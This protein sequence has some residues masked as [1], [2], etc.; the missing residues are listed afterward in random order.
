MV[1]IS[2]TTLGNDPKLTNMLFNGVNPPTSHGF[3]MFLK[4]MGSPVSCF[5]FAVFGWCNLA[6][7]LNHNF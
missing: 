2:T 4:M 5:F 3:N 7:I 1:F 6:M